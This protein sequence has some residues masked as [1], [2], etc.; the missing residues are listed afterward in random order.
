MKRFQIL[1]DIF[2]FSQESRLHMGLSVYG[3]EVLQTANVVVLPDFRSYLTAVQ[4]E[5]K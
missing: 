1:L 2:T 3:T 4:K 5:Y